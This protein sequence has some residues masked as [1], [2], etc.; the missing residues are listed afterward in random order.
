MI[1]DYEYSWISSVQKYIEIFTDFWFC[2]IYIFKL[3]YPWKF[4]LPKKFVAQEKIFGKK[5]FRQKKI[6]K[7]KKF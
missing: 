7:A 5:N 6:F 4:F 2:S 1:E 3:Q